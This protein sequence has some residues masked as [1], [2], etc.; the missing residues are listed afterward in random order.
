MKLYHSL[1]P[2]KRA[3]SERAK[4]QSYS[5]QGQKFSISTHD[6]SGFL[7]TMPCRPIALMYRPP[8]AFQCYKDLDKTRVKLFPNFTRL[9]LITHTN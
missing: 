6:A 1:L 3:R 5:V 8:R 9:H 7:T 4:Q 2:R